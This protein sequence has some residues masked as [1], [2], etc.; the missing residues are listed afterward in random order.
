M[1]SSADKESS[2]NAGDPSSILGLGHSTRE[3]IGYSFQYSWTS[4]VNQMVKYPPA[5]HETWVQSLGLEDSLEEGSSILAWEIPMDRGN[6]QAI[7]HVDYK[8]LDTM[9]WLSTAR[10][11]M[12]ITV[13]VTCSVFIVTCLLQGVFN[14]AKGDRILKKDCECNV[15]KKKSWASKQKQNVLIYGITYMWNLKNNPNEYI[16]KRERDSQ[17]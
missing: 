3:G 10:H 12:R 17:I 11:R 5:M 9:E 8:K 4:L 13:C 15:M 7:V 6:W 14:N 16:Y 1:G 2:C